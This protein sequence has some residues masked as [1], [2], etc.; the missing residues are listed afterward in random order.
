MDSFLHY[1]EDRLDIC[2]EESEELDPGAS[3]GELFGL[4][5]VKYSEILKNIKAAYKHYEGSTAK[6]GQAI[7]ELIKEIDLELQ[8]TSVSTPQKQPKKSKHS[9]MNSINQSTGSKLG[10]RSRKDSGR[11]DTSGLK[12][13]VKKV[14]KLVRMG[15]KSLPGS[16]PQSEAKDKHQKNYVIDEHEIKLALDS[17]DTDDTKLL[18]TISNTLIEPYKKMVLPDANPDIATYYKQKIKPKKKFSSVAS[19]FKNLKDF[20][21]PQLASA[22][23]TVASIS[24]FGCLST[25]K[26]TL[27]KR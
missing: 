5:D 26:S 15:S 3:E 22:N 27:K 18:M 21:T 23:K 13:S 12:N 16:S 7:H 1:W 17:Y 25:S 2:N 10:P 4:L 19:T 14:S 9:I 8:P 20:H 6:K 24:T 11:I